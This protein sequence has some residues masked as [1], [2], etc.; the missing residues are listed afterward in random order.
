MRGK[1]ISECKWG[2]RKGGSFKG[3]THLGD[4]VK[5]IPD[6]DECFKIYSAHPRKP[7][8]MIEKW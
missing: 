1:K 3:K 8:E 6:W 4:K 5:L 7:E 2:N